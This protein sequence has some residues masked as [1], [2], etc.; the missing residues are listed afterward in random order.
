MSATGSSSQSLAS[1]KFYPLVFCFF[2][3]S[4]AAALIYEIVW[5]Q[6]LEFV[7]GSTAVSLA[8][9]LGT[10]MGGMC[11]GSL[12]FARI[13]PPSLHPLRV[14]ATIEAGIGLIAILVLFVL[15]PAADLYSMIGA[16]GFT[17][18]LMRA[19]LC[20]TFLLPPTIL[21]GATLPCAA[22]F[23]ESTPKGASWL[24]ILYTGNLAGAVFGC[25]LGGFYLL[26]L[27]DA[28]TATYAGAAIN[29]L[30]ATLAF[31]L[32]GIA[33]YNACVSASPSSPAPLRLK[34]FAIY[35]TIALSGFTALGAQVVWT[36]LL[37]LLLGPSVYTFSIVLA[38]F[39]VGLGLG[40]S[41]GS[42]AARGRN[43]IALLGWCQALLI[44]AIAWA[45]FSIGAW[46]PYWPVDPRL[47][48]SPWLTFQL[49][50]ARCLWAVLPAACLWGASFPLALAAAASEH[51]DSGRMV[52]AV[53]AANTAGAIVGAVAFSVILIPA[54]GT[55]WAQ[56]IL[57]A[58][59]AL[60]VM[61]ALLL[62]RNTGSSASGQH[63]PRIGGLGAAIA[64]GVAAAILAY[65]APP[66]PSALYA[67]GRTFMNP[68]F[69]LTILYTG[70]GMNSSVAVSKSGDGSR[71]FHVAGKAEAG[72]RPVDMRL[73]RMLGHLPALIHPAPRSVLVV[74]FGAGVT[75]G[76]FVTYPEIRRIVICEIEPLIPRE[77]AGYFTEENY[78]VVKD[79][80][81]E[82]VYDDARHFVL[83]TK[84]SFDIITSDPIHPWV[85]GAA[86]L[87]TREYFELVKRHLNAGG[88]V[89]QWVPLEETTAD[90][91]KSELATFFSVFPRG[92]VWLNDREG[93]TDLVMFGQA[94]AAPIDADALIERFGR[95]G[96][97][98]A[99]Q[100][101]RD[102]GFVS[103][104]GLLSTYGGFAPDLSQWLKGA[105]INTDRGLR[106]QYLAGM[107]LNA[108]EQRE[109]HA[110]LLD[111]RRIPPGLFAG[112]AETLAKLRN[113]VEN[114]KSASQS[115]HTNGALPE[116]PARDD[117]SLAR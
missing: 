2:A 98:R 42:M 80:R 103:A 36:R 17:G 70:E 63:K 99:A 116:M 23:V 27:Y 24:G 29:A 76:T 58:A 28:A 104:L 69:P 39:L 34:A 75:A 1:G 78:G 19:L 44:A 105:A 48:I 47:S 49:D 43:P 11:A 82:I 21:M 53:Y 15:P 32:A 74:G 13:V 45:A 7:I 93:G 16:R 14:Y 107:G 101:L 9:L 62:G 95:A 4:G 117:T 59:A 66:V 108:F 55:L 41:A 54:A 35:L 12:A 97:A 18:I 60:A 94:D 50:L 51:R 40:S 65:A 5:F 83:T 100:S 10:F 87:Y 72:S 92:T 68:D 112:S 67:L 113:A 38:V 6:L 57:I 22:R 3:G 111:A 20:V 90:A 64:A 89:T 102:L 37:S 85:K 31:L 73:Q 71:N 114:S 30:C 84:E 25:L 88:L 115:I 33:P 81:V 91:V 106:L 96:N 61:P 77:I 8:V 26:R 46:L 79:P 52:G 86:S 109:I 56:R 110:G